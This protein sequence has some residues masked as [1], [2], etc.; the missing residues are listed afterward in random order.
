MVRAL[1][2]HLRNP[3]LLAAFAIGFCIL[4][5]FIG[6]FTYVNFVLVRPPIGIGM[7]AVGFVYFVFLPSMVTTP[8]AGRFV[9][10]FGART[11]IW[12]GLIVALIGLPFLIAPSL[13]AVAGRVDAGG[14]R[15]VLCAGGGDGLRRPCGDRQPGRGERPLPRLVLRAAA[16][17]AARF[18]ARSSI[19]S[20]GRPALRE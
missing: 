13:A 11:T 12:A 9:S 18:S 17:S 20:A 6:A 14:G 15:N 5:A 7:M 4:F 3:A 2:E 10:R 16:S 19:A 1:V 8:T